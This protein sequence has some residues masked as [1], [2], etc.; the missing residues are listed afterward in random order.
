MVGALAPQGSEV[1]DERSIAELSRSFHV[2]FHRV[3]AIYDEQ[4]RRLAEGA[5]IRD[6]LSVLAMRETRSILNDDRFQKLK[7]RTDPLI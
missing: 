4:L 2:P 1:R 3:A 5:R 6:F 7:S